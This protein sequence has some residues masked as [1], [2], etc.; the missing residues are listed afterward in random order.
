MLCW[1]LRNPQRGGIGG[2]LGGGSDGDIKG[3]GIK[4]GG[5]GGDMGGGDG[6][7]FKGGASRRPMRLH[8]LHSMMTQFFF[9]T[10]GST[11]TTP[12]SV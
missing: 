10:H 6:G 12:P 9:S 8:P 5:G 3:D 1:H 2:G 11:Q 7:G 4:G